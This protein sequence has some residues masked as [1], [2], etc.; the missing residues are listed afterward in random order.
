MNHQ[1]DRD[2]QVWLVTLDGTQQAHNVVVELKKL[3]FL[4]LTVMDAIGVITGRAD[5]SIAE[6]ARILPGVLDVEP[7]TPVSV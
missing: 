2:L 7:E 5:Q 4:Q 3:G 1:Q 6:A